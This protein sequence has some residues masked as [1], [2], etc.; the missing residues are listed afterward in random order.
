[1]YMLIDRYPRFRVAGDLTQE[2]ITRSYRE[3]N[4]DLARMAEQ[5]EVSERALGRRVRELGLE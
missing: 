3:H 2:E 4:G 5:L 1:M